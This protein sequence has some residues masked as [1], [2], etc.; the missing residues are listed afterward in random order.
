MIRTQVAKRAGWAHLIDFQPYID[1]HPE[2]NASDGLHLTSTGYQKLAHH[3]ADALA[4]CF[5]F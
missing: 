4:S 2:L 1:A 3:Y 5:G